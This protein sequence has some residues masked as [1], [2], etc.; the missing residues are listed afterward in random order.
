MNEFIFRRVEQKYLITEVQYKELMKLI[1]KNI[2]KDEYYK[3]KICS[4]YFDDKNNNILINS[5]EKPTFKEKI[6]LRSYDVP[7]KNSNVYLEIKEKYKGTVGKRR[8]KL[9]LDEYYK[10]IDKK[11]E[12]KTQIMKEIKYYFDLYELKP[13]VFV[14]YDRLCYRGL[15]NHNLRITF[16][17]NLRYRFDDLRLE[18][19]DHGKKFFKDKVYIM[20]IKTL[21]AMPLWLVSSLSRLKIYPTSFSKVGSIFQDKIRSEV[22][23]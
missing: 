6:R 14:G 9:T 21:D 19:G 8:S 17:T 18:L 16:D 3:S 10:F 7:D 20:E 2:E 11:L 5:L 13:F 15:E 1:T 22:K 12:C 23:C 4:I